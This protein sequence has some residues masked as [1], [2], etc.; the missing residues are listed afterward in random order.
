MLEVDD[1][2]IYLATDMNIYEVAQDV[3]GLRAVFEGYVDLDYRADRSLIV[4]QTL[5][6]RDPELVADR[7][8]SIATEGVVEAANGE[9]ISIPADSICIHGDNPN[10]VAVLEAIHDRL[11]E[12]DIELAS[13]PEIVWRQSNCTL[14][15]NAKSR[16]DGR[17]TPN[18]KLL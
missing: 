17:E 6:D 1:D 16:R 2:L 4:E 7:F 14:A 11:E 18:R 5:E 13:L 9:E 8:V 3:D 10:A 15:V 12:T